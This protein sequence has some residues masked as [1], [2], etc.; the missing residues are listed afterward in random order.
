MDA[1]VCFICDQEC[2]YNAQEEWPQAAVEGGRRCATLHRGACR[3]CL[4]VDSVAADNRDYC[5][6]CAAE[7][8]LCIVC[9]VDHVE[10]RGQT[11]VCRPAA[12]GLLR[13][14]RHAGWCAGCKAYSVEGAKDEVCTK[15]L[16]EGVRPAG[17]RDQLDEG[18]L[19]LEGNLCG[20]GELWCPAHARL[21]DGR[22]FSVALPPPPT[23]REEVLMQQVAY[24]AQEVRRLQAAALK[25]AQDFWPAGQE[26]P[27]DN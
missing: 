6:R 11:I 4:T 19:R 8:F 21:S 14:S 20:G 5:N 10:T 22:Q 24:L 3:S 1:A 25:P 13:C 12:V 17:V 23:L 26:A 9:C 16:R 18:V 15:C 2:L 7:Q 27:S